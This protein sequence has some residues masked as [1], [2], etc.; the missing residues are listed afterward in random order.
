MAYGF[1]PKLPLTV[2]QI[3]GP[4]RLLKTV[5]EIGAQNLKMLVLTNPGEKIMNPDFGVGISRYIFDQDAD[6]NSGAIRDRVYEQTT[7]YLPYINL[8]SVEVYPR[9]D[10]SNAW[11]VK[12]E[13]F[14]PGFTTREELFLN[15]SNDGSE[16]T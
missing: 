9:Q 2:D 16:G 4:Y 8:T 6:F 1:S 7:K 10:I 11:G 15:L 13:Y 14:I 3:D 12:I 5:R